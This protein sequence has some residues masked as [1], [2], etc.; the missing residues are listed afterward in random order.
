VAI[1]VKLSSIDW[2]S[3]RTISID[4][5]RLEILTENGAYD[6]NF[7]NTEKLSEAL[8]ILALQSTKKVEFLDD[9]RFNPTR[10]RI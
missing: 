6:F 1:Q 2:E 4:G 10:F 3:V 8:L 5:S 9:T 7:Q